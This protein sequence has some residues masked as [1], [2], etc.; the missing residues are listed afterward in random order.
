MNK[1]EFDNV[2]YIHFIGIGGISMSALARLCVNFGKTISGSDK[3]STPLTEE[4]KELGINFYLGHSELNISNNIQLVVFSSAVNNENPELKFANMMQIPTI[5]RSEFLGMISKFYENVIAISGTH[6]KTTTGAMIGE[7][8]NYAGLEPTIH[9]GGLASFGN[10]KIGK[11]Q[12][13]ITECCEYKN[14]FQYIFSDTA[15][16]TN[17]ENEHVDYY[18]NINE[19]ETCF[20]HFAKNVKKFLVIFGD[21]SCLFDKKIKAQIIKCGFDSNCD[22]YAQNIETSSSGSSFDVFY[23][24]NYLANF[25]ISLMGE[26]NIKNAL[27]AIAVSFLN[28]I[29]LTAIYNALKSFNGVKRRYEIISVKNKTTFIADYAHH[30]TEI[31]ASILGIKDNYKKILC[32]FQPHTYSRTAGLINE[33]KNCLNQASKVIIYKTYSAREKYLKEGDESFLFKNINNKNKLLSKNE[34]SL[35]KLILKEYENYDAVLVLGAGDIYEI[36]KKLVK[37]LWNLLTY[38]VYQ[39]I[40]YFVK[41]SH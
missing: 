20:V 8:F 22:F 34:K 32:V 10:L 37:K 33:F 13:F 15:V 23:G 27:C 26:H 2:K 35:Y 12:Y 30:P 5:E 29:N 4:L 17:I 3:T 1:I 36:M 31:Q 14:S 7:I 19:I 24:M 25:K 18:K 28:G 9:I 11:N 16:I 6:G 38:R 40:I 21:I 39:Y 41:I